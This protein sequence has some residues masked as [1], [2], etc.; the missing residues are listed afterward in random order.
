[1]SSPQISNLSDPLLPLPEAFS[2]EVPDEADKEQNTTLEN[3][4]C[5]SS[6]Q[7][8]TMEKLALSELI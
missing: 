8:I 7:V 6:P 1:M 4:Q 2:C 5:D 3:E